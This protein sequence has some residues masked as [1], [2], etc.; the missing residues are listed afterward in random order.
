M[1]TVANNDIKQKIVLEGEKEYK[2]AL[3]DAQRELKTLRSELKAETAELGKNATEQ[4]KNAVKV[5]NL[6]KQIAE[7]EKIVKTYTEAL[8][9]VKEKYADNEDEIAKWEI[10]LNDARTALANMKNGLEETSQ[11]L[12]KVNTNAQMGVVAADSFANAFEGISSIGES[13]SGSIEDIFLD[14]LDIM[15]ATIGEIWTMI[16]ET[17]AKADNWGDIAGYYGSTAEEVQAWDKAIRDANGSFEDFIAILNLMEFKGKSKGVTEWLGISDANYTDQIEYAAVVMERLAEKREELGAAK[18][19]DQFAD[20][21]GG[22]AS[23]YLEIISKWDDVVER[24]KEL[25]DKGYLL[26]QEDIEIMAGVHDELNKIEQRFDFLKDKFATGFGTV[27]LDIATNVSGALDALAKY[28][29][30][31]TPEEREEALKELR[32][33]MEEAFKTLAEAIKAGVEALDDVAEELKASE[34]PIVS[35]IGNILGGLADALQWLTKDNAQNAK[36]AL[37]ILAGVWTGGKVLGMVSTI[38]QLAGHIAT[39]KMANGFGGLSGLLSGSMGSVASGAASLSSTITSAVAAAAGPFA[40][41]I[42][43]ITMSVGLVALAVPIIDTL[44]KMFRGE[45]PLGLNKDVKKPGEF[46]DNA[47]DEAKETANELQKTTPFEVKWSGWNRPLRETLKRTGVIEELEWQEEGRYANTTAEQQALME[48]YYDLKKD[49]DTMPDDLLN[50]QVKLEEAFQ[51]DSDLLMDIQS[52]IDDFMRQNMLNDLDNP[53][54]LPADWWKR[55]ADENGVTSQDIQTLNNLPEATKA[56]IAGLIG[57][58]NFYLDGD[59]VAYLLAP[60]VSQQIA[61]DID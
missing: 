40:T 36:D 11:G 37:L 46:M 57:S 50:M 28:F 10:K 4:D 24:K 52:M 14:V 42:A 59:K 55:G 58:F 61:A 8:K 23:Q 45:D 29:D 38:G 18:F 54:D 49:I 31:E 44:W 39:I 17:A 12:Q 26:S 2:Q 22:K 30:A 16:T 32:E 43:G 15:K 27:T 3:K 19:N 13:V 20:V 56:A 53:D 60:R 5:K 48:Q 1:S 34:D 47:S 25:G 6:Q 41:A 35:T 51:N 33:N 9:E 21:F 7:Q